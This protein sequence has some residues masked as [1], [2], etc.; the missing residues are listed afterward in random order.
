MNYVKLWSMTKRQ[1][2][3][4]M[5][6]VK[7]CITQEK[8]TMELNLY[9]ISLEHKYKLQN[10]L[11]QHEIS[12]TSEITIVLFCGSSQMLETTETPR[13]S[14][15]YIINTGPTPHFYRTSQ[16]KMKPLGIT[17]ITIPRHLNTSTAFT[18][19]RP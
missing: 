4:V 8:K 11:P 10:K 6:Y 16:S 14:L 9:I 18:C 19:R 13:N 7:L 3:E 12:N 5:N 17:Q 2:Y 1:Q 15:T